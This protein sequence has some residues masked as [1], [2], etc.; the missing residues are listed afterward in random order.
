MFINCSLSSNNGELGGALYLYDTS[1]P[2]LTNCIISGNSATG[3]GGAIFCS[4]SN[5]RLSNCV[6]VDNS[7]GGLGGGLYFGYYSGGELTNCVI[8]GNSPDQ[9]HNVPSDH[10]NPT[11]RYCDVEGGYEGTGN[12]DADPLFRSF[13]GFD[14]LL[15]PSS[16]CVDSGDPAIE[17][18][19]SDWHS[20]WPLWYPNAPRS[21]MGAYGGPGNAGWLR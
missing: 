2:I 3:D 5:P 18:G 4:E 7:S 20:R 6:V 8:W 1:A 13:G 14:Y 11:L 10:W 12:I 16:P 21:D 17:D 19:V 9:I 15:A